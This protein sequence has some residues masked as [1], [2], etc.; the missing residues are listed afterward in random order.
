[1]KSI[2]I[3]KIGE[4]ANT[5]GRDQEEIL[6]FIDENWITP[7]DRIHLFLDEEDIERIKL[8]TELQAM[9]AND[10]AVPI[11]LHLIDQLNL[12]QHG[13]HQN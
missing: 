10:E 7:Y 5:C 4:A 8:I 11:I 2:T 9:G 3:F 6:Q 12:I 1:V 13:L